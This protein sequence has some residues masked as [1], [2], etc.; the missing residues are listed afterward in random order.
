MHR[1][2]QVGEIT[3][4]TAIT[5]SKSRYA[6][7]MYDYMYVYVEYAWISDA[8][9]CLWLFTVWLSH[10]VILIS[11]SVFSDMC[12]SGYCNAYQ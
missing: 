7:T 11:E 5:T 12:N 10:W 6:L 1:C 9:L 3:I 4:E 2:A 8:C